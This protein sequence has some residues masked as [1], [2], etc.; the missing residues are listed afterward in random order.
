M[1]A[2]FPSFCIGCGCRSVSLV[3]ESCLDKLIIIRSPDDC[4]GRPLLVALN[5]RDPLVSKMIRSLKFEGLTEIADILA[6]IAAKR[7][8]LELSPLINSRTVI[9]PLPIHY[10]RKITR[11][12][13]QTGLITERIG[14]LINIPVVHALKRTK[15]SLPQSA[16]SDPLHRKKNIAHSFIPEK[17]AVSLRGKIAILVDDVSTSGGTMREAEKALRKLKPKKIILFAV[18]KSIN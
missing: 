10:F 8:S 11:G 2:L 15:Y 17:D 7:L 18:A 6:K 4:F 16:I 5:Y 9:I 1:E 14:S 3:C 13:D 12:F